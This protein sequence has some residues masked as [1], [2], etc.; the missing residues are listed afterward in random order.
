MSPVESAKGDSARPVA[1]IALSGRR[2][3]PTDGVEDYC[4]FLGRALE[5]RGIELK[6]ARVPWVD[7]GWTGALRQLSRESAA[8][9]DRWVLLQYTAL[10]WS[11][12]S[13]PLGFLWVLRVLRRNGAR[14]LVV[15]HDALPYG[16]TRRIDRLRRAC[17]LWVMRRA[18]QWAER[19]VLTIPLDHAG[20]LPPQ[21]TKAAFIPIGANL[22][23][24]AMNGAGTRVAPA[25][26][27]IAVFGITGEPAT[28]SEVRDIGYALTRVKAKLGELRLVAVGRGSS[29][30]E[31][32]LRRVLDG[33]G[34]EAVVLGLLTPDEIASTL[35]HADV[36]L[37]VRGDVSS[38]RGSALAGIA[39]GLPIVGYEG[40]ET[41]FPITKAGLELAPKGDRDALAVALERILCD[42]HLRQDLRR[43]SL[44][45]YADYFS[46]ERIAEQFAAELS[47]G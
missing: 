37:F 27:T 11:R 30:A 40:P 29:E 32:A 2:D 13:F 17:Q 4:V 14:C 39:C 43:R 5:E 24:V 47:D 19:S 35:V 16:G 36:L 8:W 10:G 44:R 18:Y 41:A 3:M 9:R 46:W 45:A 22:P 25:T 26:K 6:L 38:R 12:R 23:P 7:R 28:L 33:S 21:P 31:P 42:D 20:W 15:F 1:W 34:V